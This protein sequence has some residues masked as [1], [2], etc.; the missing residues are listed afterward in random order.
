MCLLCRW[1][2]CFSSSQCDPGLHRLYCNELDAQPAFGSAF[3]RLAFTS[4]FSVDAIMP[5]QPGPLLPGMKVMN[6]CDSDMTCTGGSLDPVEVGSAPIS[7]IDVTWTP[8]CPA[9][10][11]TVQ[12]CFAAVH[13][14]AG[15]SPPLIRS[16]PSCVFIEILP[17]PA[18]TP[19][20]SSTSAPVYGTTPSPASQSAPMTT[21]AGRGE[22]ASLGLVLQ[23]GVAHA[24]A[25]EAFWVQPQVPAAALVRELALRSTLTL[26]SCPPL[27]LAGRGRQNAA[28]VRAMP[29]PLAILA[30]SRAILTRP[31]LSAKPVGA[32]CASCLAYVLPCL[33][34]ASL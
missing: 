28:L 15:S 27:Q 17:A 23:Q 11:E 20:S 2:S 29:T 25:E 32:F 33:R 22:W 34:P 6:R 16:L 3:V 21:A 14:Q 9:T 18:P 19:A 13:K 10:A 4:A 30:L 12:L 7:Y 26:R 8:S 31:A 5:V 24:V 1:R